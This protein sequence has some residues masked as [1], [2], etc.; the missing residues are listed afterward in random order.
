MHPANE[1]ALTAAA[2][3]LLQSMTRLVDA[4]T[5]GIEKENKKIQEE[6]TKP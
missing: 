4:V 3:A 1:S 6:M 5:T 2:I